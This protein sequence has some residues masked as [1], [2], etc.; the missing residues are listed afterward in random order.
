V[1]ESEWE[2]ESKNNKSVRYI[3]ELSQLNNL[4]LNVWSCIL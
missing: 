2:R 4:S 3:K 1:L